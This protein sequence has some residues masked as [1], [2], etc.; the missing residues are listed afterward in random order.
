MYLINEKTRQIAE[1]I[2]EFF[3][4]E[5][6]KD[7]E[8]TANFLTRLNISRIDVLCSEVMIH[9]SRPGLLIGRRGENVEKL[10]K[11]LDKKIRIIEDEDCLLNHL[12]PYNMDDLCY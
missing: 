1:Q 8:K 3:L 5:N 7:Y 10:E 11:F 9:L 2:G 12:I 4:L 6:N